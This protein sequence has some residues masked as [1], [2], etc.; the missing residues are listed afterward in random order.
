MSDIVTKLWQ[1]EKNSL[2]AFCSW[3][4]NRTTDDFA[5]ILFHFVLFSA[6][7]VEQAKSIPVHS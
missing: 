5:A 3:K 6:A 4:R 2:Y 1:N 7:L